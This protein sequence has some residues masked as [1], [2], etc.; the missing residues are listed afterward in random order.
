MRN[1]SKGYAILSNG[2]MI[3]WTLLVILPFLLLFIS[4]ITSENELVANGY[5]FFPKK[6]SLDAYR[7]ILKSG[8]TIMQ[9]YGVSIFVTAVGTICNVFMSAMMAYSLSVKNLP[10]RK[11][12]NFFVFFTML[13]NGGIVP[14]Y[15]MWS[16]FFHIKD[17]IWAQLIPNL[18]LSAWNVMLMRTYFVTNIPE[19]LYEAAEIDGASHFTIFFK[20]ALPLSKPILI[21]M[22]TFAGL[23]YWNNW[24]NGLYYILK[25]TD[26]YNVQN[27]LNQMASNIQYLAQSDSSDA[28]AAMASIPA[29]GVQMAIAFVAILPVTLIFLFLQKYYTKGIMLGSVK[30]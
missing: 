19:S 23:N 10:G 16:G 18:L 1:K 22:G 28:A 12:M 11:I 30:G 17:T 20:L 9:A 26:L 2:T 24:N 3:F 5:S 25:R 4:S 13:F 15:L 14:S 29:T 27:L 8:K 21:T 6:L 7:Y